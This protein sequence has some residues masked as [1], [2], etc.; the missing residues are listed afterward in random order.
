M[1]QVNL[2]YIVSLMFLR[3]FAILCLISLNA[4]TFGA[5][6]KNHL[7]TKYKNLHTKS[8]NVAT[9]PDY[10]TKNKPVVPDSLS[11]GAD[12]VISFG[13]LIARL[14]IILTIFSIGWKAINRF[15][16]TIVE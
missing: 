2:T 10:S 8:A 9:S 13:A 1:N 5:D 14:M 7:H 6:G 15:T 4:L 3:F 11:E 16:L 12:R